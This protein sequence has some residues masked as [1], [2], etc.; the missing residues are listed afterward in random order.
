MSDGCR[1]LETAKKHFLNKN[2]KE[3]DFNQVI[4]SLKKHSFRVRGFLVGGYKGN[5]FKTPP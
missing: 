1:I 3:L 5:D 2:I 4:A